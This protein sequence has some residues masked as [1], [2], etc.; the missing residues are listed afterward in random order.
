MV[1][2]S[3]GTCYNYSLLFVEV[4]LFQSLGRGW[5]FLKQSWS[6]GQRVPVVLFPTLTGLVICVV[7][8]IIMTLPLGALILYIRKTILGQVA[9]GAV[10]GLT[11]IILMVIINT[12]R[13]LSSSLANVALT[14]QK[15]IVANA[16]KK[17]SGLGADLF[18]MG[19]GYPVYRVWLVLRR[20]FR[21]SKSVGWEDAEHLLI[22]VLA[23][24][25]IS[26]REAS[27][28][29]V[30]MQT[31]NCVFTADSVGIRKVSTLLK[32]GAF[33]IGLAAGL[34]AAWLVLANA[35]D[36]ERSL[37]L[38]VGLAT[39]LIAVFTLPVSLYC[40]YAITLFNTCLY[41]WGINVR[42]ARK[43]DTST[44]AAVPEPLTIA[45]GIRP[46]R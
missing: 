1:A 8:L 13:F 24:E 14:N 15:P 30:K 29:I 32:I 5:T 20:L 42:D 3:S 33:I 38:A 11:L 18:W 2:A 35:E 21:S 34:G 26:M 31:D 43:G 19:L 46:G 22:P 16:W 12:M 40:S 9:I 44:N 23:N 10:I 36:A 37:V 45:L 25:T 4:R 17:I 6:L 41:R 39:F 7:I 28:Q 27:G